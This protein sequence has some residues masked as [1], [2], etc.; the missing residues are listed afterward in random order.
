MVEGETE[1]GAEGQKVT[2]MGTETPQVGGDKEREKR[3]RRM[4]E[5]VG[6][7]REGEKPR[8]RREGGRGGGWGGR[9]AEKVG[10]MGLETEADPVGADEAGRAGPPEGL[11]LEATLGGCQQTTVGVGV[12]GAVGDGRRL[13]G[14]GDGLSDKARLESRG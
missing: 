5:T 8:V 12:R 1:A 7:D 2:V 14:A 10:W 9:P 3:D 4:G 6:G 13:W 11:E